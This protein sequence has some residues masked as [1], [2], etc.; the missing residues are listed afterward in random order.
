M[1]IVCKA[2]CRVDLAGGTLDI[3][4]LY[5]YH[6]GAVTVNFAIDRYTRCTVETHKGPEIHLRSRDLDVSETYPSLGAL[7]SGT[8]HKHPLAA[9]AVRYFA[10]QTGLSMETHS[11]APA[12]AGISGS[13]ALMIAVSAAL[14]R[15]TKAGHKLEK[16]REI[17]QNVE[18]QMIRVP[19]GVQD[20]YAAMYGGVSAIELGPAGI[21]RTGIPVDPDELNRRFVLAYTGAPRN[22]GI[23]NWEVTKAYIDGNKQVQRNFE[24]IASIAIAM[25]S[26]LTGG[27]WAE[28][29]RLLREEWAHRRKNSPSITT[30]LIDELI[31]RTRRAGAV[32][33]KVCGAGGG[34]CVLFLVEP[35]AKA[36]VSELVV[37][38]GGTVLPVKV[39]GRG[40]TTRIHKKHS[41]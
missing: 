1:R 28:A 41:P 14:N 2:P 26:A 6:Q 38:T 24:Q 37:K 3:W 30:P 19:T 8:R 21:R 16:I 12:G 39:A 13:S 27:D 31:Q 29:G 20:Y 7:T 11:E 5:L 22:S 34:G 35:E 40:L 15:L 18:A 4:P 25:R 9:L 17:A 33:A 23:N 32:G 10:P 36:R